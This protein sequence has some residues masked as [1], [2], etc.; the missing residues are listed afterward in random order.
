M[1]KANDLLKTLKGNKPQNIREILAYVIN[2]TPDDIMFHGDSIEIQDDIAELFFHYLS[3]YNAGKP[4]SKIV[5]KR[6]FWNHDFYIDEN[7]LDPRQ[8]SEVIIEAVLRRSNKNAAYRILDIGTGS[9]CLIISLL[10]ELKS[11]TGV[12]IDISDAALKIAKTNAK[13]IIGLERIKFQKSD[14]AREIN[15]KFDIIVS[16]PPY[17]ETDTIPKLDDSVKLYDPILALDGGPNGLLAY[18]AISKKSK[19]LLTNNGILFLEIGYNQTEDV[20]KIFYNS[21]Y[22]LNDIIKDSQN[23]NRVVI[24][25]SNHYMAS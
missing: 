8:D 19:N 2:K 9:G 18:E 3:E 16:N 23:H 4:I 5:H 13:N 10:S 25:T 22:I 1:M 20:C 15:E 21:G 14:F 6:S 7:V 17:I 24:F 12:G 11:S